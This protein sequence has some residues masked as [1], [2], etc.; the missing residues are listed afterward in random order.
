MDKQ[1]KREQAVLIGIGE[2][3]PGSV[4]EH[5]W[6]EFAELV[7]TAGAVEAGRII[8]PRDHP[9]PAFFIGS[10]KAGLLAELVRETRAELV[11]SIQELSSVQVRN[12]EDITG[13]RVIDRTDLILDIF[14]GRAHTKEGKLQVELARLNYL[15][16]RLGGQTQLSRLGG[17]IGTRG[18]GE[19]KLE[20][21]KRRI[22][23]R[24]ADLRRQ[25]TEVEKHRSI[26]RHQREKNQVPVI[27]L[28][29]YT[30]AG[31]STL[32]NRLTGSGVS[33]QNRLFDTL[34]PVSRRLR[35]PGGREAIILDT[36]G[37]I[38]NLPHQLV[39]AFKATLEETVR[40]TM[41]LHVMD[42]G[43]LNP[44]EHFAAVRSVLQE[45]KID[46]KEMI[47]VLNKSDLV[48]NR[49]QLQQLVREW[50]GIPVSAA[51]GTG[52]DGLLA[53]IN[54][55]LLPKYLLAEGSSC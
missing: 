29:G 11:I 6:V 26:Q 5:Y 21:N 38:S 8:Q 44:G 20:V 37:F 40:S 32:F 42:A 16:P 39:A 27:A 34:D 49:N 50:S 7:K 30:N 43:V 12:L 25:L 35:L 9:D 17:G 36:V 14:A 24:I 4:T 47:N 53:E 51:N 22:K 28:I 18:P 41:L 33:A 10:G 31:K 13:V 15:L 52:I 19:T 48:Q 1:S 54:R 2:P 23:R 3:Q 45:L 55:R 46:A